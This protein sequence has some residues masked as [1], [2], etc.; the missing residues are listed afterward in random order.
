MLFLN[1]FATRLQIKKCIFAVLK[2]IKNTAW[3]RRYKIPPFPLDSFTDC[4]TLKIHI[5]VNKAMWRQTAGQ[6]TKTPARILTLRKLSELEYPVSLL[7]L[8]TMLDTLD[9][10]TISRSLAV[11]L[12]RHAIHS[13]EDGSGST[14]YEICRSTVEHCPIEEQHVHFHCEACNRTFCMKEHKIPIISLPN[15]YA[16]EN[17][18]YTIKGVCPECQCQ[19]RKVLTN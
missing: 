7:E 10:S 11:L 4:W 17:I 19:Q 2:Q 1:I 9:K 16:I 5:H 13:F 15:G 14:K 6:G 3:K 8:E 18:N 12:K